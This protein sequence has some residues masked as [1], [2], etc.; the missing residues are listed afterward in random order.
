MKHRFSDAQRL[1]VP[2]IEYNGEKAV[3]SL[4]FRVTEGTVDKRKVKRMVRRWVKDNLGRTIH[5]F[6]LRLILSTLHPIAT[7]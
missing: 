6:E 3:A 7:Y 1:Y 5:S 2:Y 4:A